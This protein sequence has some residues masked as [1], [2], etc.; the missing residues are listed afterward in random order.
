MLN[1]LY[2]VIL[3]HEHTDFDALASLFGASLLF[4][5]ALP[6]LPHSLNRNVSNFLAL[7]KNQ[8]PFLHARELLKGEI[9]RVVMVDTRKANHPKGLRENAEIHVIDHH[10]FDQ[11]LPENWH[12]WSEPV[13]ANTTLLVEKFMERDQSLS[14]VQA[15]LLA[16][17]IHEN[18]GSLT[19]ANTTHRDAACLAWLLRP[20]HGVN[21]EV[22]K[23]FLNHPLSEEQRQLLQEL[24]DQSEFIEIVGR[25]VV[26]AQ[27]DAKNFTG[28]ISTL[29]HR[30]VNFHEQDA[31]FLVINLGDV[32]Q[33]VARGSTDAIDV[34]AIAHALGGG[35]HTRAA[36]AP[37]HHMETQQVRDRIVDLLNEQSE[38]AVTVRHIM[39]FGKPKTVC[40]EMTTHDAAEMMRRYGHEGFPVVQENGDGLE[41]IIGVLTR[42]ETDRALNHN[43]STLSV[44]RI[45]Q[46]GNVFVHPSDSISTLRDLMINSNWGQIPVVDENNQIIG[47][48]TRTDLIKLWDESRLSAECKAEMD[49]KL[50]HGL[51]PTQYALL[52]WIGTEIDAMNYT[53][54]IVGGYVRDLLLGD[55]VLNSKQWMLDSQDLDCVIEG[56]AIA[57]AQRL[58]ATYGG[59]VIPHKRFGTAKWLLT[60]EHHPVDLHMLREKMG[61]NW[62]VEDLPAHLDFVSTRTEFYTAPTVLPTVERSSIKLD[63]LRRDFSIN[64][65]AICLSQSRWADLLDLFGGLDDLNYGIIQVLH[66]LSFVDD[67]TRILRAVRYEQRFGFQITPRTLELLK[68]A[69]NLI[70][71][72]SP[73]R[74]RHELERILQ[75]EKPEKILKRL[76]QLGILKPI[77]PAL[78]ADGILEQRFERLRKALADN[79]DEQLT[80]ESIELLYWGAWVQDLSADVHTE[81]TNRLKLRTQTV[82]LMDNLC[83][84]NRCRLKLS[85]QTI[86]PSQVVAI[87][88]R[89]DP[90]ALALYRAVNELNLEFHTTT[91]RYLDEWQ[92][93]W[94]SLT[95]NDLLRMGIPKGPLYARILTALRVARLDGE[96]HNCAEEE[97]LAQQI[98]AER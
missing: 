21:L 56:D 47:I 83:M 78:E 37:V 73:T 6:V 98:A 5:S 1:Q 57:F 88:D 50:R 79:L 76:D 31:T 9:D 8:F 18:T 38:A 30:L 92:F 59:R 40:P 11:K 63:L 43:M 94:P 23:Q 89:I 49:Q 74:I 41:Q 55:R 70:E 72:V 62:N 32:V 80:Q 71:R 46:A 14:S 48:V 68:D 19:Y 58:Q 66:S 86:A 29:A 34:G 95:G 3:T 28:E 13:G 90:L 93:I 20:E 60:D 25:Q 85:E 12:V 97:A 54:Y 4:P 65:L 53:A 17:G 75:E 26:I 64:T 39:S 81:L 77:H 87:L 24:V 10:S 96:I 69:T 51:T 33:V 35:G 82:Q 7:Y 22:L 42:R 45:M 44:R 36:A 52:R 16:L 2:E 27:A 84:L 61:G 15:T 91:Q 67:P